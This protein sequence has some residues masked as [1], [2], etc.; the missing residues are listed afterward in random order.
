MDYDFFIAYPGQEKATARA[1]YCCLEAAGHRVFLDTEVLLPGDPWDQEIPA[2]LNLSR[3]TAVLVSGEGYYQVPVVWF[4][5]HPLRKPPPA[6][7]PCT[8]RPGSR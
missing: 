1:L 4:S 2:A 7:H 3:I 6:D 5:G 8:P